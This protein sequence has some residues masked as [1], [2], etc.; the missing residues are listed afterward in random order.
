MVTT[1]PNRGTNDGKWSCALFCIALALLLVVIIVVSIAISVTSTSVGNSQCSNRHTPDLC[2]QTINSVECMW[3]F[4]SP[5]VGECVAWFW[6]ISEWTS[7]C[8]YPTSIR[9]CKTYG[10][11]TYQNK[12]SCESYYTE[13]SLSCLVQV[14]VSNQCSYL[15]NIIWISN[16]KYL[17]LYYYG[18]IIHPTD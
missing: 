6:N 15:Y 10:I 7:N 11:A 9:I 1:Q 13:F 2:S 4:S 5:G 16:L 18:V 14:K 8:T 3:C 12:T 17:V